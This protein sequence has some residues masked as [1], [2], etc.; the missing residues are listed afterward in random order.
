MGIVVALTA[1]V[2]EFL[3]SG[4]GMGYGTALTPLLL[5]MGYPALSV[6]PAVLLSQ[7]F[8][9]VAACVLHHRAAN[10]DLRLRS[11]D[12]RVAAIIGL[13]S[14]GGAVA[15]SCLALRLSRK[16]LGLY[17]GTVV[18]SMGALIIV[19][20]TRQWRFS[21]RKVAA[22]SLLAA[23]NKG[24]S[25][26]GYGPLVMGGQMLSGVE[27]KHAVGITAFAEAVTC[28]AGFAVYCLLGK[29][30]DWRLT[31][32]LTAS[33]VLAVPCAVWTVRFVKQESLRTYAAALIC[34]L[35]LLTLC[36]AARP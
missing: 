36:K 18:L 13:L 24:I 30:V 26:G 8:T 19:S 21:W 10:V 5:M 34:V 3:D 14:A 1:F 20:G 33:A 16:A 22:I 25:G 31:W 2:S 27:P 12:F 32:I 7:L 23:F 9:D 29:T 28:L 17:I 35:G 4:L 6:V 15:A 11:R